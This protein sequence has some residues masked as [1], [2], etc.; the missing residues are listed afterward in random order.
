MLLSKV[1]KGFFIIL[2]FC[3]DRG[4][5]AIENSVPPVRIRL[6]FFFHQRI[7]FHSFVHIFPLFVLFPPWCRLRSQNFMRRSITKGSLLIS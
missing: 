4:E 2:S 6:L 3:L 1:D 5:I 7:I